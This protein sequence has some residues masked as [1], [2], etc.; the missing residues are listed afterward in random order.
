MQRYEFQFDTDMFRLVTRCA[1]V[2]AL[3]I[4]ICGSLR[5]TD[6]NTGDQTVIRAVELLHRRFGHD[7]ARQASIRTGELV[8]HG[9]SSGAALWHRIEVNLRAHCAN[10]KTT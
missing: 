3:N 2:L 5:R 6:M 1:S 7:A 4:S 9:D 8:E 10:N